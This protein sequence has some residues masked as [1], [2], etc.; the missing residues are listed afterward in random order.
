MSVCASPCSP[1]RSHCPARSRLRAVLRLLLPWELAVS[2][3]LRVPRQLLVPAC[4]SKELL[5]SPEGLGMRGAFVTGTPPAARCPQSPG[6]PTPLPAVPQ[7]PAALGRS[8]ERGRRRGP[9]GRLCEQPLAPLPCWGLL[10]ASSVSRPRGRFCS[11]G[12]WILAASFHVKVFSTGRG[13]HLPGSAFAR[14]L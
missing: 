12:T 4:K 3:P 1:A 2:F 13:S 10:G 8:E 9:C 7:E 11:C 6:S 5:Q 14:S